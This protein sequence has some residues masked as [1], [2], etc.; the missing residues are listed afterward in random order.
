LRKPTD[1]QPFLIS[2]KSQQELAHH[3][4]EG[5]RLGLFLLLLGVGVLAYLFHLLWAVVHGG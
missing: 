1:G 3:Q 2:A 5:A 4:R